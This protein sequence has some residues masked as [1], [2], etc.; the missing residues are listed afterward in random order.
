MKVDILAI[1]AHPDDVELSCA[2]TLAKAIATGKKVAILD[3]TLGELGTR[4]SAELRTQE[5]QNAAA[6]LGVAQRYNLGFADGFFQN[7]KE[8][9]L[10]VIE[11]IRLLQPEIVLCNATSDRHPDHGRAAKLVAESCFLSGLIKIQTTHQGVSQKAWRPKQ[12]YHYIQW[13]NAAP[14]FVVDISAQ[15]EIK[16]NAVVAYSSQFFKPDS[17]EPET[18]ISSENFLNS[19]R[20]R[21]ADLG[22]MVGVA[23]A[24]GFTTSRLLAVQTISDLI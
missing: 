2:G 1:G 3:L 4:G 17:N 5:A 10:K 8:H 6:V 18:P 19:I 14:D 15:I 21:A 23:Y 22:R 9:Q 13:N 24:E 7:D 11:F 16:M 12:L 20:Y